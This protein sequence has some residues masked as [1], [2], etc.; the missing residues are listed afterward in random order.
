MIELQYQWILYH[1]KKCRKVNQIYIW[2]LSASLFCS[3]LLFEVK[4]KIDMRLNKTMRL[5]FMLMFFDSVYPTRPSDTV[6]KYT[7]YL[8][9]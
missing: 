5:K 9:I 8:S 7:I 4:K 1:L 2:Q 3:K 6:T